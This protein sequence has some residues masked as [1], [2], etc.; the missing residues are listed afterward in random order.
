M[1]KD[2]KCKAVYNVSPSGQVRMACSVCGTIW[3][4]KVKGSCPGCHR[5]IKPSQASSKFTIG[6]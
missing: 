1:G 4:D 6:H 2:N 5:S 3:D